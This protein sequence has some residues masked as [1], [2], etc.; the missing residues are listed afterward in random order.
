MQ[1]KWKYTIGA[2]SG[3]AYAWLILLLTFLLLHYLG[4][5]FG[6][7]CEITRIQD[8]STKGIQMALTQLQGVPILPPWIFGT[9]L[10][11]GGGLLAAFLLERK[12]TKV[13]IALAAVGA[14]LLLLPFVVVALWFTEVNGMMLG[15]LLGRLLPMLSSL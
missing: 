3:A 6:W 14:F 7:I 5:L 10:G 12:C 13:R 15:S 8:L 2:A 4:D 1:K 9:I 11:A